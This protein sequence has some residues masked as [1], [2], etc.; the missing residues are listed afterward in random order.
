MRGRVNYIG[1][2]RGRSLDATK[3]TVADEP[4]RGT[5]VRYDGGP[6]DDGAWLLL[7]VRREPVFARERPCTTAAPRTPCPAPGP[8]VPADCHPHRQQPPREG[9]TGEL[10]PLIGVED[11]RAVLLARTRTATNLTTSG[12]CR[13]PTTS[14]SPMTRSGG[15]RNH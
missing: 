14:L 9:G 13:P 11:L 12:C 1:C 3:P 6:L 10:R 2:H 4:D 7:R 8:L 5:D 15:G